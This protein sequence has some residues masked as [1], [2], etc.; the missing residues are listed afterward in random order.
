MTK[1]TDSGQGTLPL[2]ATRRINEVCNR[3]ELAWQAGQR[4]RVEDYLGDTPEPERSALLVELVALEI[5]CRRQAGE[6]PQ[7][8]EYRARFPALALDSTLADRIVDPAEARPKPAAG[9]PAVPGY[10]LLKELG[11]GGMAVVYWAWQGSLCRTVALKMIL[12]G[13]R[14]GPQEL[15]R[16]HTEAEAVA[17]LQ[18]PHIVQVHEVGLADGCPYLALEYVNGGTLAQQLTGTPLPVQQAAR[19]VEILARAVHYAHERGV[20]HRDLTPANV[21]LQK[22]ES[23]R[24]E[25]ESVRSDSSSLLPLSSFIPKITDFGLAKLLIGAGPTLTHSGTVLGT[26]SYMAPE[27]A[28]GQVKAIGPATD[29]YALG[30]ILYELLTGRPPFH[31]ETPLETL[32][33]VAA[34]EPVPPRRLQW[35]LPRDP[36][37][38]CLK[39]LRKEP[40]RRYAS[41]LALADD[42]R[43]FQA[44]EP[45]VARPVGPVERAV[46]WARRR[47][48]VTA[49]LALVILV[50]AA[51]FGLVTWQWQEAKAAQKQAEQARQAEARQR[52]EADAARRK[53]EEQKR[54]FQRLSALVSLENGQNLCEQNDVG[55]GALWL[56][57]SLKIAPAEDADL[58]RV[59]RANLGDWQRRLYPLR[60]VFS[61]RRNIGTAALSPDGKWVLTASYDA[62]A[63]LWD[64]AT[65][66]PVT[67]LLGHKGRVTAVAFSRDG[68]L[69][70][71][72]STDKTA[73]LWDARTGQPLGKPLHHEAMVVAVAFSPDGKKVLTASTDSTARLWDA[74][75]QLIRKLPHDRPP[76]QGNELWAIAFS[77]D[78]KKIL[79]ASTD[80]TARL[81]DAT[82]QLIRKLPHDRPVVAVAFSPNGKWCATGSW[83]QTA[84]L[85]RAA[86]GEAHGSPLK[87]GGRV[88]ALAFSPNSALLLTGSTDH[89]AH[90]WSVSKGTRFVRLKHQGAVR[91]VAFSPDGDTLVT[92]SYDQTVRLWDRATRRPLGPPLPHQGEVLQ[93]ILSRDGKAILTVTKERTARLWDVA[94]GT[95]AG[96]ALVGHQGESL[97]VAF[98]PDGKFVLTG[99]ADRTARLWDAA[100][101]KPVT[102]LLGHKGRV[103]AVAFSSD[104][105]RV[106]TGSL[107]NT[108][109]LW[110]VAT[111]KPVG[112]PL[113]HKDAV[114][115]VAF[116]PDGQTAVTA[117]RDGTARLWKAVTGEAIGQPLRHRATVFTA[118]FSPDGK[119]V[120]T[121]S[122]DKTAQLWDAATGRSLGRTLKHEGYVHAVAFSRDG[123]IV[124]TG[125]DDET[126]RLWN[127]DTGKPIGTALKHQGPVRTLAFSPKGEFLLTGSEDRTARLWRVP[128]GQLACPPLTHQ[129]GVTS[130]AF[131]PEGTTVLTGSLDGT[132][133]FWDVTTGKALGAP[134]QH[135]LREVN[136]M[137]FSPD[138][139]RVITA[140]EYKLT[141]LRPVPV[142][143]AG[144]VERLLLWTQVRS[145]LE[146]GTDG[147]VGALDAATW[148]NRKKRLEQLGGPPP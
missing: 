130:L 16:F 20:V 83:D 57:Q 73:R 111:G 67:E 77:P 121:G 55:R 123:K 51:G 15:T 33:Q 144:G 68:K 114:L 106:L 31:A 95:A 22:E 26:P 62:T 97:A 126:V 65:G 36:E 89:H 14:A 76:R 72:G 137:A 93:A 13:A 140:G 92:G 3:F 116:S 58:Q 146:L 28:A 128:T 7:L 131:S 85:W 1:T 145:G 136:A 48:A 19:F 148:Q 66:E 80:S 24:R 25:E 129:R 27:Q 79:T 29:V 105:S 35:K 34:M 91:S 60:A 78:G 118:A 122:S 53:E 87:H 84:R 90:L 124:A 9:L 94:G 101:G 52:H 132:A 110:E 139:K 37:T 125:S 86:T 108:A 147:A 70:V 138:G 133:R 115:A 113:Q 46:K 56:A 42:L 117:S 120:V 11:R 38:I 74:T 8:D 18:H 81:W 69:L 23:G 30:A 50:T 107:D 119:T 135:P 44:G 54:Q 63:R 141:R 99:S 100:T 2:T 61:H 59:I 103:V 104:G 102:E 134:L 143:V 64:A 39:C 45:I 71:T 32:Q 127:A 142:P 96:L 98:S 12:A 43:R 6:A 41:A 49:L 10:E 109:R 21:L 5:D 82:G 75:G 47:P 17:R 4:P 112:K 88:V 40:G